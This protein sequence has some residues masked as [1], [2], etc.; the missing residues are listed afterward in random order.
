MAHRNTV[1]SQLLKL[2]PGH[3]FEYLAKE[4]HKGNALIKGVGGIKN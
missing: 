2:V 4:H 1:L 3:D